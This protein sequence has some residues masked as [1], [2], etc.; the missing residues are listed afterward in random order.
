MSFMSSQQ[1]GWRID[2]QMSIVREWKE[3]LPVSPAF[4]PAG[5]GAVW[6]CLEEA[7]AAKQM[8]L[9]ELAA[10]QED[11]RMAAYK[12]RRFDGGR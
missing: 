10:K 8:A 1:R 6:H 5:T 3:T 7:V 9:R 4:M 11:L 2:R 12:Q